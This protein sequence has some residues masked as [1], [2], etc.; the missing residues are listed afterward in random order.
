M[1]YCRD[2]HCSVCCKKLIFFIDRC[3]MCRFVGA[4]PPD[5]R[6]V[7][8]MEEK[9][10]RLQGQKPLEAYPGKSVLEHFC[11]KAG[12]YFCSCCCTFVFDKKKNSKVAVVDVD[13]H[14]EMKTSNETTKVM[15]NHY[16]KEAWLDDV[17]NFTDP[18]PPASK[19]SRRKIQEKSLKL[20][21][22]DIEPEFVSSVVD[23]EKLVEHFPDDYVLYRAVEHPFLPPQP[24]DRGKQAGRWEKE[25]SD[26]NEIV[27][28]RRMR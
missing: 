23:R 10:K 3:P 14:S 27:L 25:E 17:Y 13:C 26:T 7:A 12:T 2:A 4:H 20:S 9:S 28:E 15:E 18:D 21:D 24:M 11:W 8:A 1:Y 5:P 22:S 6:L 19:G 16:R